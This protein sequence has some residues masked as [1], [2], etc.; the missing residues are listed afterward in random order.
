MGIAHVHRDR[1]FQFAIVERPADRHGQGIHRIAQRDRLPIETRLTHV[2]RDAALVRPGHDNAAQRFQADFAADQQ[3]DRAGGIAAGLDF[4]A[5]GIEDPH[6]PVG[7]L[8]R[9]DQDKLVAAD[10]G[11]PVGKGRHDIAG[12]RRQGMVARVQHDEVVAQ[13][14][15]LGERDPHGPHLC[16]RA[17]CVQCHG[18]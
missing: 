4:S 14:M 3:A 10:A 12:Q 1:V 11:V 16:T 17:P 2:D 15:H 18:R 8:A 5:V 6:A 7:A 9:L 13:A